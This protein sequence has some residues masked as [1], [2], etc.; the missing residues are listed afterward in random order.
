M[1]PL[2]NKGDKLYIERVK[3][4]R[5]KRGDIV[6]YL[7]NK[8]LIS[9]RVIK[10]TE[11]KVICKGDNVPFYDQPVKAELIIG[12]VRKISGKYG[13][14]NLMSRYVRVLSCYFLFFSLISYYLPLILRKI[15]IKLFCGR[16]MLTR[17]LA[18]IK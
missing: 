5:L 3:M 6:V 1:S 11:N 13:E 16:R 9:H 2:I 14:L 7:S 10:I 18:R 8:K 4:E 12:R 15:L 17:L